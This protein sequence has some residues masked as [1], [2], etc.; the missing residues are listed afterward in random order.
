MLKFRVKRTFIIGICALF[1]I[2][3]LVLFYSQSENNQNSIDEPSNKKIMKF[4]IVDN[5]VQIKT[6]KPL[7]LLEEM[8]LNNK[9]F[10][11][12]DQAH[13]YMKSVNEFSEARKV[14]IQYSNFSRSIPNFIDEQDLEMFMSSD[15]NRGN[16]V[17]NSYELLHGVVEVVKNGT[18]KMDY[19]CGFKS[20]INYFKESRNPSQSYDILIP[21]VIPM[22]FLFQHF[23]DG[24]L[25]K[26]TQ[27]LPYIEKSNA[28]VLLER[29]F[30][31]NVYSI[32]KKL[33]INNN[34]VVWHQR[35][36]SSTVYHAKFMISTCV[37]PPLHPVLWRKMRQVLGVS[38]HLT[39]PFNHSYVIYLTRVGATNAGRAALNEEEVTNYLSERYQDRFLIFKGNYNFSEALRIFQKVGLIIGTH[40][41]AF[42]NM[43]YAP[44]ACHVIEFVPV[45]GDG[46]DI[47]SL[48]HAI[49]WAQADLI[50][51]SY[52]RVPSRSAN[53]QHDMYVNIGKL[54]RI[55]DK[56]DHQI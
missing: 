50:G 38:E 11:D 43:N 15:L 26:M 54:K 22:G 3:H 13:T 16:L 31:N 9:I 44:K 34:K 25:P 8:D 4:Q 14:V 28:K 27:A 2:A 30:H 5:K 56:I 52:W 19:T 7:K 51:Q 35:S 36:D 12:L 53:F 1:L 46:R 18:F 45:V 39:L 48:P 6:E 49:F 37:T 40:G 41:G 24:T 21:L 29:P 10:K 55:L 47:P 33:G 23:F 32:L 17:P 42:Y 20:E